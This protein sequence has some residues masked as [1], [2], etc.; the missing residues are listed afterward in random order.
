MWTNIPPPTNTFTARAG[1]QTTRLFGY[2]RSSLPLTLDR[3]GSYL[4]VE[5]QGESQTARSIYC[6]ELWI[7]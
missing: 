6:R 3:N 1:T 4:Q 7:C 5:C 2:S